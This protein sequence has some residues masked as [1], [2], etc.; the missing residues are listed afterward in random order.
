MNVDGYWPYYSQREMDCRPNCPWRRGI[1][2]SNK[3]KALI[4]LVLLVPIA[5]F[6]HAKE[7]S[8]IQRSRA[9]VSRILVLTQSNYHSIL[10]GTENISWNRSLWRVRSSEI[11]SIPQRQQRKMQCL[12][13]KGG[14]GGGH[15]VM[16]PPNF[17]AIFSPQFSKWP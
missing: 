12:I 10:T 6:D 13:F 11:C 2:G 8:I 5:T 9:T 16:W 3:P 14:N 17:R 4:P 7:I 1:S 15:G